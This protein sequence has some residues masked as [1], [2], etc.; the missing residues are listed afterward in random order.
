MTR[1][2]WKLD[3]EERERGQRKE[4][5]GHSGESNVGT[6]GESTSKDVHR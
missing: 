1:G 4:F 5:E 6:Q 3:T 2:K